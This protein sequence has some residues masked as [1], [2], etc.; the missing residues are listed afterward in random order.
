MYGVF[1]TLNWCLGCRPMY[2]L[3]GQQPIQ[4]TYQFLIYK[5]PIVLL[6]KGEVLHYPL[7]FMYVIAWILLVWM[8]LFCILW[9]LQIAWSFWQTLAYTD[10]MWDCICMCLFI[11]KD[12]NLNIYVSDFPVPPVLYIYWCQCYKY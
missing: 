4:Y 5:V 9:Q 10:C 11:C 8:C 2:C 12:T 1:V 6:L 7:V 3:I